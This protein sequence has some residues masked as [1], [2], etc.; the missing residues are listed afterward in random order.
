M[1]EHGANSSHLNFAS[2]LGL[3]RC[4]SSLVHGRACFCCVCRSLFARCLP[5]FTRPESTLGLTGSRVRLLPFYLINGW[6]PIAVLWRVCVCFDYNTT[7]VIRRNK[8]SSVEL[9]LI[10]SNF[11][12]VCMALLI[13]LRVVSLR[14]EIVQLSILDMP[15][16]CAITETDGS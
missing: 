9:V 16:G 11:S 3:C 4:L 13:F 10:F 15:I 8:K 12:F 14:A 1:R 5:Y 7:A 2:V 6:K